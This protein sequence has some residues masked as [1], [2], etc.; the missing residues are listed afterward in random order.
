MKSILKVVV[1]SRL[2]NLHNEDSDYDYRGIFVEDLVNILS[3]FKKQRNT[4]WVEGVEDNTS[5][6]LLS[7]CKMACSGNM[8]VL[9]VLNSNMIIEKNWIGDALIAN[10]DKFLSKERV[11]KA[12]LG[13]GLNQMKK[14][15]IDNPNKN[16]PKAV[17]AYIRVLRQTAELL[18]TG[19]FNP[20]Y[21]YPDRD[22]IMNIKYDFN[23]YMIPA[24]S[25]K[26]IEVRKNL[27]KSY[28][29]STLREE[30]DIEW[31]EDFILDVYTS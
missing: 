20:V 10:K 22:F 30:P 5:Y 26:I 15:S 28:E 4:S 8:T 1:G 21:N 25:E 13:Y 18:E 17:I 31:V 6:E 14:C 27:E 19:I 16:T 12:G 23:D 9:E 2:H 7:F 24:I 11:Y 29:N 3:P